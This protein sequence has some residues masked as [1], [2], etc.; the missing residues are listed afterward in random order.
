MHAH[1]HKYLHTDSLGLVGRVAR[2]RRIRSVRRVK[3]RCLWRGACGPRGPSYAGPAGI[4]LQAI[5]SLSSPLLQTVLRDH[6]LPGCSILNEIRPLI[7]CFLLSASRCLATLR[8]ELKKTK[9]KKRGKGGVGAS[10]DDDGQDDDDDDDDDGLVESDG[11]ADEDLCA[12]CAESEDKTLFL[13]DGDACGRWV[14]SRIHMCCVWVCERSDRMCTVLGCEVDSWRDG[15]DSCFI[16]FVLFVEEMS[17]TS[18]TGASFC[19]SSCWPSFLGLVVS[20]TFA[21]STRT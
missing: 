2:A 3:F 9:K 18:W 17:P 6:H 14:L 15:P 12:W 11:E 7:P 20:F 16:L 13:C 4:A 5:V 10:E 8:K 19:V 1:I 21:T